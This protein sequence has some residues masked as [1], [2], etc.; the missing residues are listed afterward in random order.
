AS[1]GAGTL[2]TIT[3]QDGAAYATITVENID[4]ADLQALGVV[5][6]PAGPVASGFSSESLGLEALEA[7]HGPAGSDVGSMPLPAL[8]DLLPADSGTQSLASLF[9]TADASASWV[10]A[11]SGA[12]SDGAYVMA[13]V[14][15]LDE[16]EPTLAVL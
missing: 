2:V 5:L 9:A 15:P 1:D 8:A 6:P 12:G 7:M 13:P 14:N 3:D 10:P 4:P 16:L 11:G